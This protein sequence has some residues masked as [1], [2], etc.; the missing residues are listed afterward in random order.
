MDF[1]QLGIAAYHAG[2]ARAPRLDPAVMYA[3]RGRAA[4][5]P[6]SAAAIA[7]WLFGWDLL[8]GW[9]RAVLEL[10]ELPSLADDLMELGR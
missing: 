6:R 5:D 8:F 7:D 2:L 10:F 3:L 9:D 1:K 4:D